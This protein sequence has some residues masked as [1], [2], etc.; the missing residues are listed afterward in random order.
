MH[1][2]CLIVLPLDLQFGL[3]FLDEKFQ[4]RDF[5]AEFLKVNTTRLR[6]LRRRCEWRRYGRSLWPRSECIG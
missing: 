3:Q 1:F 5:G 2:K 6:T 4:P